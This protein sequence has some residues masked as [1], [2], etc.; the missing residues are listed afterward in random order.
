MSRRAGGWFD[1]PAAPPPAPAPPILPLNNHHPCP[2][3]LLPFSLMIISCFWVP[4]QAKMMLA[5][6][7]G[8]PPVLLP[9]GPGAPP[10]L[11]VCPPPLPVCFAAPPACPWGGLSSPLS[12]CPTQLPPQPTPPLGFSGLLCVDTAVVVYFIHHMYQTERVV[13]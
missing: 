7:P 9:A 4:G 13:L 1:R 3:P 5:A 11:L 10:P 6:P 12:C 8:A 2:T